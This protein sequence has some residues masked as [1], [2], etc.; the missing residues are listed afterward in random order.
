MS[1]LAPWLETPIGARH[2][3]KSFDCGTPELNIY[4]QRYARQNH[5]SGGAKCFVAV[6]P[7]APQRVL[8]YYTLSP[9]S[10][11]YARTP[12]LHRRGLGRYDVP[13]F[14][15]G[16]LAVDLAV[17]GRGL[18]GRLLMAAGQRALLVAEHVGG[19]ALIIDAKDQRA[20]DWYRGYGAEPLLDAALSLVLPLT[21]IEA[22]IR[23][24][25]G[26]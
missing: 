20:A 15:L 2:D 9:A 21:T 23:R 7:E 18:G 10:L 5:V 14:R 3:R 6:A 19:V 1:R 26:A 11:L 4:L 8:G 22:A 12:E 25:D 17:Q 13:V 16:R 24:A